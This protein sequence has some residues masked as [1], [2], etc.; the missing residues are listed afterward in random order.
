MVQ[1]GAIGCKWCNGN[2]LTFHQLLRSA[3]LFAGISTR[4]GEI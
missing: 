1:Y 4:T 2:F 3:L